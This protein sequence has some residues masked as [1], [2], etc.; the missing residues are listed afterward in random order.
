MPF[1]RPCNEYREPY[2]LPCQLL[3]GSYSS[4]ID[5]SF[6]IISV[7]AQLQLIAVQRKIFMRSIMRKR[8]PKAMQSHNSQ[9]GWIPSHVAATTKL[10]M[11]NFGSSFKINKSYMEL[12]RDQSQIPK[13]PLAS[14]HFVLYPGL[15]VVRLE[16]TVPRRLSYKMTHQHLNNVRYTV[17]CHTGNVLQIVPQI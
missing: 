11:S 13:T 1:S 5:G 8:T 15:F 7:L 14:N 10:K 16:L 2:W 12:D 3:Y 17:Q 4:I 6:S 9:G